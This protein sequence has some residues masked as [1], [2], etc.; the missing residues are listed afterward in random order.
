MSCPALEENGK[1]TI[2]YTSKV[3]VADGEVT[4]QNNSVTVKAKDKNDNEH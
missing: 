3:D 4:S 1:Y 2:V